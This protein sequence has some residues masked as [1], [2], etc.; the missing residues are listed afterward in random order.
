[1]LLDEG[2]EVS[3][4]DDLSTGLRENL[5]ADASFFDVNIAS[6]ELPEV[7][8][9]VRPEFVYHFAF[10]VLV[11]RSVE[12][13][14]LDADSIV[15]SI[16]LLQCARAA[17]VQKIVFASSGFL[18]GN[19]IDLPVKE[20]APIDPV[21]PYVVA[22]HAVEDYLEFFR[23]AYSL[24][25]VVLRYAAIYG[26]GQVT[27]AM[28]DYIRKLRAGEQADIWGDGTK[29]RD[30][31]YVDDVV[32]ANRL[33]LDVP[34]DFPTPVFNVGTGIETTLNELYE[35]IAELLGKEPH[36]I[37]HPDRPGEQMRYSLDSTKLR[38]TLGW[39]PTV[40][41]REGLKR[42]AGIVRPE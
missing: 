23:R 30:Y 26:P 10:Q 3:I 36:P 14:L 4:V 21:T 41:L 8:D 32:A 33:A 5:P 28:A 7:F 34:D 29:T 31:V 27:G 11:P 39:S 6:T 20:T 25:Y 42:T 35:T 2:A 16:N 15:G 9:K 24:P 12:N 22:K 13:P 19:T 1:M 18:Y 17:R 37:Y 40:P 38:S